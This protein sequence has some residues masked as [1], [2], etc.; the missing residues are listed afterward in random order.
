VHELAKNLSWNEGAARAAISTHN[1]KMFCFLFI[2]VRNTHYIA[3]HTGSCPL[4]ASR[5]DEV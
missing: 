2:N 4:V 1:K 5:H 3:G